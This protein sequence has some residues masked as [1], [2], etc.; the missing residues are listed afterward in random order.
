MGR[1]HVSHIRARRGQL[2]H[3]HTGSVHRHGAKLKTHFFKDTVCVLV[4]R[5]LHGQLPLAQDGGNQH[6]QVIVSCSQHYLLRTAVDAT[7][8]VKIAA[9]SLPKLPLALRITQLEQFFP[10][11]QQHISR[12]LPPDA[13][14]EA[15][16]VDAIGGEIIFPS[17]FF[18]LWLRLPPVRSG[19]Q[20]IQSFNLAGIIAFARDG[21]HIPFR[22]Q[23]IISQIHSA[24]AYFQI[25]RKSPA[26]GKLLSSQDLLV[27]NILFNI[28]VN[29][30]VQRCL[31]L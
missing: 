5:A 11:V 25:T 2:I 28:M 7:G 24:A 17:L 15:V 27:L 9:D 14:G 29:L 10:V 31:C 21:F 18:G 13:V 8:L 6:H 22:Q 23:L 3:T 16:Q 20:M 12:H 19:L 1:H 30:F 26:G 4:G